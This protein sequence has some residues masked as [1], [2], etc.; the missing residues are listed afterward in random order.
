MDWH[1]GNP[2]IIH[3]A[4]LAN[5][6]YSGSSEVDG[7]QK[8]LD[9]NSFN[10]E[11]TV[12]H[13]DGKAKI[14]FRGTVPTNSKDR[15]ADYLLSVGLQD[16]SNRFKR[17]VN[18]VD[19]VVQKYGKENVSVTG[20]SLGAAKAAYVSRARGVKSTG[21]STPLSVFNKRTYAHHHNVSTTAD[22]ISWVGQRTKGVGKQTRAKQTKWDP[23]T[24]SNFV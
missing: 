20:H 19:K 24:M 2:D 3:D 7:W 16:K 13:K 22:P 8:D 12:Y 18:T 11:H 14:A 9:F 15:H 17:A 5:A 4:K 21:F 1:Q 23:H 10:T 6:A